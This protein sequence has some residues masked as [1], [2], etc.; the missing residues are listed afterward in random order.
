M[1][2][3]DA[4]GVRA[5]LAVE[6]AR[7]P[8]VPSGAVP[9]RADPVAHE[10]VLVDEQG[11]V[12]LPRRDRAAGA[13]LV[14]AHRVAREG[15]D[16]GLRR[17]AR[18]RRHLGPQLGEQR[19]EPTHRL[20][21]ADVD[22]ALPGLAA[23][24]VLPI[25]VD[26]VVVVLDEVVDDVLDERR[27]QLVARRG[28]EAAAVEAVAAEHEQGLRAG[29]VRQ[30]DGLVLDRRAGVGRRRGLVRGARAL[31]DLAGG[32]AERSAAGGDAPEHEV[33]HR[34]HVDLMRLVALVPVPAG[35]VPRDPRAVA[36]RGGRSG[37][38]AERE[39]RS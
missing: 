7:E 34:R 27:A 6:G 15:Q 8:R 26:A 16:A 29:G 9:G 14:D 13:E 1:H 39:E 2:R 25:D 5:G 31:D 28:D 11:D 20:L 4:H 21:G 36:R 33:R 24:A 22:A 38:G 3:V 12:H 35:V 17:V 23:D 37:D 30:P 18:A 10:V 19:R 32:A